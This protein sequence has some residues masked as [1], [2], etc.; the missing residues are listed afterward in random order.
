M[1][2]N[3]APDYSDW[4]QLLAEVI[5]MQE[6][7][8]GGGFLHVKQFGA[9]GDGITDDTL[10]ILRA[11]EIA[12]QNYEAIW[13]SPGVYRVSQPIELVSNVAIYGSGIDK[14]IVQSMTNGTVF[15]YESEEASL[16]NVA[17]R[18]LTIAGQLE[19]ITL[20]A[21]DPSNI[22][23]SNVKI[24]NNFLH[25]KYV[26]DFILE[27]ILTNYGGIL[28][29]NCEFGLLNR[30]SALNS[31]GIGIKIVTSF[32]LNGDLLAINS[33]DSGFHG[34]SL[35]NCEL[36]I[37]TKFNVGNQIF[38]GNSS[39]GSQIR[40]FCLGQSGSDTGL[41]VENSDNITIGGLF[42]YHDTQDIYLA[43]SSSRII[44]RNTS[45]FGTSPLHLVDLSTDSGGSTLGSTDD[46]PEGSSNYYYTTGR[47]TT[48]FA[49]KSTDDLTEGVTNYYYSSEL[50]DAD[51]GDQTTDNLQQGATN[52]YLSSSNL[53]DILPDM[54]GHDDQ[55]LRNH[56]GALEWIAQS[57]GNVTAKYILQ[58]ADAGLANAQSLASLDTGLLKNTTGTGVLS[59][60]QATDIG[61]GTP[62]GTKF[63][64]DDLSWQTVAGGPGGTGTVREIDFVLFNGI[65]AYTGTDLTNQVV[66]P[67]A[68]TITKCYLY[69]KT[70]PV[71]ASLILDILRSTD[72]GSTWTS[73]W[74]TNPGNRPTLA[75]TD[76]YATFTSF[77][78]T[79]LAAGDLLRIDSIQVGSS[80]PG[81]E[82]FLTLIAESDNID[83]V[84]LAAVPLLTPT[85]S[86]RNVIQPATNTVV[87]LTLKSL[88]NQDENYFSCKNSDGV[89]TFAIHPGGG[90]K[91]QPIT[92]SSAFQILRKGT[93]S[94]NGQF[95]GYSLSNAGGS[96]STIFAHASSTYT[97]GGA[98]GWVANDQSFIYL[99]TSLRIGTGSTFLGQI[100]EFASTGVKIPFGLSYNRIADIGNGT[101]WILDYQDEGYFLDKR[102]TITITPAINYGST[103]F[104]FRDDSNV[105]AWANGETPW[106]IVIEVD[107]TTTPITAK[108]NGTY[109]IGITFR[110]SVIPTHIKIEFWNP[111]SG[112]SYS[113]V[114]DQDV[115]NVHSSGQWISPALL[116]P[117]TTN[118]NLIKFKITLTTG[119]TLTAGQYVRIQ[120]VMI[121]HGSQ[122]WDPWHL[123]T[124]GGKLYGPLTIDSKLTLTPIP[125]PATSAGDL[126]ADTTNL[127][128][129]GYTG[130]IKGKFPRVL[131][132]QIRSSGVIVGNTTA[133]T[134]LINTTGAYG[135]NSIPAAIWAPGKTIQIEALGVISTKA[136]PGTLT[137]KVKLGAL[138]LVQAAAITPA[139]G[140]VSVPWFLE[141]TFTLLTAA[142]S[143]STIAAS[144]KFEIQAT[145]GSIQSQLLS[146]G[147][148]TGTLDTTAAAAAVITVQWQTQD[149][150]NTLTCWQFS[151][152]V[153]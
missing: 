124:G 28:L 6:S 94:G 86:A 102:A 30:L 56:S 119:A 113:T 19:I 46:L 108:S 145:S 118:Y 32:G 29:E 106:P 81:R 82:V 21:T 66:I 24:L 2:I 92:A 96:N 7:I 20:A 37:Y 11:I 51:F 9:V 33:G 73:L 27:G 23:I 40:A 60:A 31:P 3:R 141:G 74:A 25:L 100:V 128:F 90:V 130:G 41:W 1:G 103:Y 55:V 122:V 129:E 133:E 39:H 131:Y 54:T 67:T 123:H 97:T 38:I 151:V 149:V 112:G 99:A 148:G 14:T 125:T 62:D 104:L 136:T 150:N 58:E 88:A 44:V 142:G 36:R 42:G 98:F 126:W 109:A 114:Y 107:C 121:Y 140:L 34:D 137:V 83:P 8:P 18:D 105:I 80:T 77:D 71:G 75:T 61:S 78:T 117:D 101:S 138:V 134:T 13:L 26:T 57:A 53:I 115:S 63:L 22:R 64:R 5:A 147:T 85:T 132:E 93:G 89:E 68:C 12:E 70:A 69:A 152:T 45:F 49:T 139:D 10:A 65:D 16:T 43:D 48:D 4:D 91:L 143:S 111:A 127:S 79:N 84:Q 153:F 116:S 47:F 59:I 50:F 87:A 35:N 110:S 17:I 135:S 76:K 144:G 52:L 15:Y 146:V 120:R 72:E 95:W